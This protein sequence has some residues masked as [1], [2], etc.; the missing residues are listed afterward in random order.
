MMRGSP[1]YNPPSRCRD[2]NGTGR[3]EL[4][5][6]S[7]F[8]DCTSCNGTGIAGDPLLGVIIALGFAAATIGFG[9][10]ILS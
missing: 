2:C 1:Q 7:D 5:N 3:V 9:Y 4:P 6:H 10:W 8:Y